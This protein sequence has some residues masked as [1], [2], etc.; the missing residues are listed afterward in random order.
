M[1]LRDVVR[2]LK[3]KKKFLFVKKEENLNYFEFFLKN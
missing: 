1:R 2:G 3:K